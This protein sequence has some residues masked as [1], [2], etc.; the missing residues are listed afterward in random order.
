MPGNEVGD[1]IHNFFGQEDLSQGQHHPQVVDASWPGLSNNLWAGNQRQFGANIKNH[2][3]QPS[4]DHERGHGGQSSIMQHGINFSQAILRPE[5]GR[6][7]SQNQPTTLNGYMHGHQVFATR[8]NET[9]FLGMDTEAGRHNLTSRGIS[10]LDSQLGNGSKL[11]QKNSVMMDSHESPVNFNFFGGPQQ[12]NNQHPDMLQSLSRQQSGIND[13]QLLQQQYLIKQM[14]EIQR[15]QQQL[16]KQQMQQQEA[17]QL[18]SLNQVSSFAQQAASNHSQYLINGVP[19][20]AASNFSW[21]PDLVAT[22]P[23]WHQH[24]VLSV[25]QASSSGHLFP[26]EEGQTPRVMGMVSQQVD[27]SLYG[28]PISGTGFT[29]S[30]Y[31]TM[32]MENTTMQQIS[33]SSNSSP[34]NPYSGFPEQV[35]MQEGN[36]LSGQA[37]QVKN[38]IRNADA[39]GVNSGFNFENLQQLSPRQSNGFMQQ[40]RD[41]HDVVHPL[42]TLQEEAMMHV[43]PLQNVPTLDP[44]E[45]KILF[46]SD[47]NLLDAFG[48]GANLGSGGK[49]IFDGSDNCGT[50]PSLQSGSWSALMQS[51]VAETS[52][53]DV[54]LQEEWSGLTFQNNQP[55]AQNQPTASDNSKQQ[56]LPWTSNG[57]QN[58]SMQNS[59]LLSPSND[60]INRVLQ[61]GIKTSPEQSERLQF[62]SSKR[63]SAQVPGEGTKWLEHSLVQKAVDGGNNIYEKVSPLSGI[64]TRSWTN[65]SIP[66]YTIGSHQSGRP[67]SWNF[68]DSMSLSSG[69]ALK[70]A[71]VESSLHISQGT[72]QKSPVFGVRALGGG[73]QVNIENS[74]H[75][76]V[77]AVSNSDTVRPNQ[78]SIQKISNRSSIDGWKHFDSSVNATTNEIPT[79]FQSHID[80]THPPRHSSGNNL[81]NGT[82]EA[83]EIQNVNIRENEDN[84]SKKISHQA[85]TAGARENSWLSVSD[86]GTSPRGKQKSS[87]HVARKSSGIR[88]FQYHPM[89]DVEVDIDPS[90]EARSIMH[91]QAVPQG[92]IGQSSLPSHMAR[93]SMAHSTS[94]HGENAA[95]KTAT[96][97]Q[98]MLELLQ[99]VDQVRELGNVIG[100]SSSNHTQSSEMP[101]ADTSDGSLQKNQSFTSQGFGL[102]LAPPSQRPSH[103]ERI[104]SSGSP[105]GMKHNLTNSMSSRVGEKS[106]AWLASA[107]SVQSL[108][109]SS[110]TSQEVRTNMFTATGKNS[111]LLQEEISA[112]FSPGFSYPSRHNESLQMNG[113][114]D[115]P[116]YTQS[117]DLPINKFV[118]Q[119]DKS[120][121]RD[122]ACEPALES[123]GPSR[124]TAHTDIAEVPYLGPHNQKHASGSAQQFPL[125]EAA[126]PMQL[127]EISG[128][129]QDSAPRKMSPTILTSVSSQQCSF[130]SQPFRVWSNMLKSN[131]EPNESLE[132]T[133]SFSEKLEDQNAQRGGNGPPESVG[134]PNSHGFVGK[135]QQSEESRQQVPTGNDSVQKT[136]SASHGK[137]AVID[138]LDA[139]ALSKPVSTQKEIEAFGQSLI[140]SNTLHLNYSLMH[141]HQSMKDSEVDSSSRSLKRFKG[142][143]GPVVAQVVATQ[144]GHTIHRNH[145]MVNDSSSNHTYNASGDP[146]MLSFSPKPTDNRDKSESSRDVPA[147]GQNGTHNF[148]NSNVVASFRGENSSVSPQMAPSWFNQ[149]GTFKNGQMLP[150]YDT[151]EN[152][153]TKIAE[154][155]F[156]VSKPSNNL[157]VHSSLEQGDTA[158]DEHRVL[159]K[160]LTPESLATENFA[161]PQILQTNS[162][163]TDMLVTSPKKRKSATS[164]LVPWYKEVIEGPQK[165]QNVSAAEKDWALAV[166]RL[167]EKVEDE[168]EMFNDA[169]PVL[170]SRRRLILTTQLMQLLFPP[171]LT[172]I[173]ST[174][175]VSQYDGVANVVARSTL[176]HACSA[177][178]T[179]ID[180]LLPLQSGNL[181]RE[182]VKTLDRIH[183]E[184][185]LKIMEDLVRRAKRIENVVLRLDK[186]LSYS[187]LRLEC[188]E[189][190]KFSVINR[191]AKFH[192]R[193][194]A[195]MSE[196][197]SSDAPALVQKFCPQRYVTALPMPKNLPD[198]FEARV[199]LLLCGCEQH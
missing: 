82:V 198:R 150:V 47:D 22:S 79:K 166:N 46:G 30:H 160:C 80:K 192:G 151:L 99:K 123:L 23:N 108:P 178:C 104:L 17:R 10:V 197:S 170:R 16:Q 63:F 154:L 115:R 128:M 182:K 175:A 189:L 106:C 142:L 78:E 6:S 8:Q 105:S 144:G 126:A 186:S 116:T 86:S 107:S 118:K 114:T 89:G 185:F 35:D 103:P 64:D 73:P 100:P 199:Q 146:K 169:S 147:I 14:Q 67:N 3:T 18:N 39:Q 32:Q 112:A 33:G 193:S 59:R 140:P 36:S 173:L 111:K 2:N 5:F 120:F 113:T 177:L 139:I 53:G 90:Q 62:S 125:L 13:M 43:C 96:S 137:E 119:I 83:H 76:P 1:R 12:M 179:R 187:D 26:L 184:Y 148:V 134:F 156:T 131:V 71:H 68:V 91:S 172:S 27:L 40:V 183:D 9:N 145:N 141:Q 157:V 44:T 153:T 190:G 109:L 65:H 92:F 25:L 121:E 81:D 66:P 158:V 60:S 74:N 37:Y 136:V 42:G 95:N 143:D 129:S 41:R 55:P 159:K 161:S 195:D 163:D 28:V 49:N 165:L 31:S 45:E 61:S 133:L 21:Q 191:F 149:Y 29:P 70:S 174:G 94:F 56:P 38:L 54:G 88:K 130:G 87:T 102:Q 51:A 19:V 52:Q 180:T 171:P 117:V 24:G 135:E 11:L 167:T 50:F 69:V 77:A 72:D 15:R 84:S 93:N 181:L 196:M 132:T 164:E 85:S 162:A 122:P 34:A 155:P 75:N 97:S 98:N 188:Q 138:Y 58:V 110:E 7:Q 57:L 152:A 127:H 48:K 101:E 124:S 194:Q 20:Q 168:T 4:A 176:G